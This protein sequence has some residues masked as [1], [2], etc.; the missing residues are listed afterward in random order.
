MTEDQGK[1]LNGTDAAQIEVTF[2]RESGRTA[3]QQ[4]L[5]DVHVGDG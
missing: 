2:R 5:S 4:V 3:A 1:Q